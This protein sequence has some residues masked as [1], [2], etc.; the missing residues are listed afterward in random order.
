MPKRS[1][2][3]LLASHKWTGPAEGVV[4]LVLGLRGRGKSVRFFCRPQARDLLHQRARPMGL[5]PEG[6]LTLTP[7][8]FVQDL[9]TFR[10]MLAENPPDLIHAHLS[11]D[12][13][14]AGI[15]ARETPSRVIRTIHHPATMDPRPFRRF[16]FEH[17][18]DGVIT[19][20]AADRGRFLDR[21]RLDPERVRVIRGSVDADRFAP[22]DGRTGRKVFGISE[23]RPVIGMVAR[24]QPRRRHDLLLQAMVRLRKRHP[25]LILLLVGRGEH[26][27]VLRDRVAALKLESNVVFTGFR[28]L[29]LPEIVAAMDV[30]VLLAS[31]SDGSCRAV[32]EAMAIGR[33]V[34]AFPVGALS[35]TILDGETGYLAPDGSMEGL[36]DRISSLLSNPDAARAMGAA[37][38]KRIETEFTEGLRLAQTTAFYEEIIG[39]PRR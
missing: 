35:E 38:R 14:L 23:N 5:E 3:H 9:L 24:F 16:L 11:H 20:S 21:Y 32:L 34:V 6:S 25:D 4:R 2:F 39:K 33:P 19:L 10:G 13:L 27:A 29:D 18:T 26:E 36:V 12:H 8:S 30:A 15:A 17:W 7:L 31:G 37:A 22:S 1:I 28:D